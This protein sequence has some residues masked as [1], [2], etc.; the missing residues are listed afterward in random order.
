L[1][2]GDRI[3]VVARRAGLRRL[4]EDATPPVVLESSHLDT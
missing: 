1:V 4:L 2:A 3:L